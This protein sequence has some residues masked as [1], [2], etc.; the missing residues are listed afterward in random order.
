MD[1]MKLDPKYGKLL[2]GA[3]SD[4]RA[5]QKNHTE[6]SSPLEES[7]PPGNQDGVVY[8]VLMTFHKAGVFKVHQLIAGIGW[9]LKDFKQLQAEVR[10][11]ITP[12]EYSVFQQCLLS[13]LRVR[14]IILLHKP[15]IRTMLGATPY[16][17]TTMIKDKSDTLELSQQEKTLL[18]KISA[19]SLEQ[20]E[21]LL[22]DQDEF[23]TQE[24]IVGYLGEDICK[25]FKQ[26]LYFGKVV[27]QTHPDDPEVI[28]RVLYEDGDR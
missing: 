25:Y 10:K 23:G 1:W 11:A 19:S 6:Q 9:G 5:T 24:G 3:V 21:G 26:A 22:W 18:S 4:W 12:K 2:A 28:F 8:K 14:R 16:C 27:A 7:E 15:D 13:S 20:L 17:Y